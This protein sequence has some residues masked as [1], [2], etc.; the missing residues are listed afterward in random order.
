MEATQCVFRCFL[1][2]LV[3]SHKLAS[4]AFPYELPPRVLYTGVGGSFMWNVVK[5]RESNNTV[6][7]KNLHTPKEFSQE[8]FVSV[9]F[10]LFVSKWFTLLQSINFAILV[11][12]LIT[13]LSNGESWFGAS[14][15]NE[16]DEYSEV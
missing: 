5:Y 15:S 7:N 8:F 10:F 2:K 12:S 6:I 4:W 11:E 1:T 9:I 3:I 16:N 13:F 14:A